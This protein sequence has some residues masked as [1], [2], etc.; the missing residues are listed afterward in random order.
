MKKI[1]NIA[2]VRTL[3]DALH[4]RIVH[5]ASEQVHGTSTAVVLQRMGSL[6]YVGCVESGSASV[7]QLLACSCSVSLRAAPGL[8]RQRL[9]YLAGRLPF[10][11]PIAKQILYRALAATPEL[12]MLDELEGHSHEPG[13]HVLPWGITFEAQSSIR[14]LHNEL[15]S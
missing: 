8:I 9:E 14:K 4:I 11:P 12:A 5:S 1:E 10:T 7:E 2:D 6:Y 13:T 15:T 3:C